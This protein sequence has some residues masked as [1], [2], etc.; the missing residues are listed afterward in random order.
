MNLKEREKDKLA[1]TMIFGGFLLVFGA[2]GGME[3]VP[4]WE[5]NPWFWHQAAIA[6]LGLFMAFM[7]TML[8]PQETVDE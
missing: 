3:A 5:P 8:L 4:V 6:L 2:V 1:A 7:G